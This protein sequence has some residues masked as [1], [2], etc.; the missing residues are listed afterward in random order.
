[1][2]GAVGDLR[3]W[4]LNSLVRTPPRCG[5]MP[6]SRPRPYCVCAP[7]PDRG[8]S[9]RAQVKGLEGRAD[10]AVLSRACAAL[11]LLQALESAA[12]AGVQPRAESARGAFPPSEGN[13]AVPDEPVDGAEDSI[14]LV[15]SA[16]GRNA[17]LREFLTG[18]GRL[19]GGTSTD[20]ELVSQSS[21]KN[22]A[23]RDFLMQCKINRQ[24]EREAPNIRISREASCPLPERVKQFQ[25]AMDLGISTVHTSRAAVEDAEQLNREI[26]PDERVLRADE[27]VALPMQPRPR[28]QRAAA[29]RTT[30]SAA[31]GL[32]TI[33]STVY[34]ALPL[35]AMCTSEMFTSTGVVELE[36]KPHGKAEVVTLD[37]EVSVRL[38]VLKSEGDRVTDDSKDLELSLE[39]KSARMLQTSSRITELLSSQQ[40]TKSDDPTRQ[41]SD[42]SIDSAGTSM[43]ET[44]VPAQPIKDMHRSTRSA[45]PGPMR[46]SPAPS[47]VSTPAPMLLIRAN[48]HSHGQSDARR[49]TPRLMAS[50]SPLQRTHV[51]S[52]IGA[53]R[54][55]RILQERASPAPALLH[56]KQE[57]SSSSGLNTSHPP[58]NWDAPKSLDLNES[59]GELASGWE[60]KHDKKMNQFFYVNH[61]LRAISWL[62]PTMAVAGSNGSSWI[63]CQWA[64][65]A[66]AQEWASLATAQEAGQCQ[67]ASL[68]TAQEAGQVKSIELVSK[69]SDYQVVGNGSKSR[70]PLSQEVLFSHVASD[71]R[72]A[73]RRVYDDGDLDCDAAS[74][75][76]TGFSIASE[77]EARDTD[78]DREWDEPALEK[79]LER[80]LR[81]KLEE[82]M[83]RNHARFKQQKKDFVD[84]LKYMDLEQALNEGGAFIC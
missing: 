31:E 62:P 57:S 48:N 52:C 38:A 8:R 37:T 65:L 72:A 16:E 74:V 9:V 76:L 6:G 29:L 30:R 33:S 56:A 70:L 21:E 84:N 5:P 82:A 10:E 34:N 55:N 19:K 47:P 53:P 13:G 43:M 25:K 44:A 64:S 18:Q 61:A 51:F 54:Q 7:P 45:A 4:E 41:G 63:E 2:V 3:V 77:S 68:A 78:V 39:R 14:R 79:E 42:I 46:N 32:I 60:K 59:A 71:Q 80:E 67:W 23:M 22:Y 49:E 15:Q 17:K 50:Q 83:G 11:S 20:D 24:R 73:G 36:A 28:A 75:S 27:Q 1:M 69:F 81:Q 66:T 12:G 40:F 26:T 58:I 35:I